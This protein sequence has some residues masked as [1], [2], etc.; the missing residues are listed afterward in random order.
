MA[1]P[2]RAKAGDSQESIYGKLNSV[3]GHGYRIESVHRA[4]RRLFT[5]AADNL[6][7]R[8]D[9]K[10]T[11]RHEILGH[12]GLNE[13]TPAGKRQTLQ[14][15]ARSRDEGSLANAWAHVRHSR[16]ADLQDGLAENR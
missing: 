1:P 8:A 4:T 16:T 15:V 10:A 2:L 13:F 7:D 11:L 12:Y 14:R 3:E 6:R 5:L 9:A